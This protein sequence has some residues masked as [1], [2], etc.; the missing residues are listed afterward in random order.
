MGRYSN[1]VLTSQYTDSRLKW[2]ST[3]NNHN[4]VVVNFRYSQDTRHPCDL[5]GE[6]E[7]CSDRYTTG[8]TQDTEQE[9]EV[10]NLVDDGNSVKNKQTYRI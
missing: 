1:I 2:Q 10:G 5:I 4:P 6:E 7:E 9:E 8:N 3:Y